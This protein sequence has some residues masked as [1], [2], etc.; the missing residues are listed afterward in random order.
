MQ[1]KQAKN[2]ILLNEGSGKEIVFDANQNLFHPHSLKCQHIGQSSS[3]FLKRSWQLIVM[4]FILEKS[5]SNSA[6]PKKIWSIL[7]I[8]GK[9]ISKK[10]LI[11]SLQYFS[12][13]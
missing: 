12:S 11:L 10:M 8:S 9:I 3:I 5:N 1:R 7:Y 13:L 2:S 6:F 4:P